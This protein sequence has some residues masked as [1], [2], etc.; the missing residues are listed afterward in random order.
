MDLSFL[1]WLRLVFM[2]C[3]SLV[4][5]VW[6]EPSYALRKTNH[7][8]GLRTY[9]VQSRLIRTDSTS[10]AGTFSLLSNTG[11]R[12]DMIY[13]YNV[14]GSWNTYLEA[15]SIAYG[16]EGPSSRTFTGLDLNTLRYAWTNEIGGR[17]VAVFL[18]L[19]NNP[20]VVLT[21]ESAADFLVDKVDVQQANLGL[22]LTARANGFDLH[23]VGYFGVPITTPLY[24]DSDLTTLEYTLHG[25]FYIKFGNTIRYGINLLYQLDN[26]KIADASYTVNQLGLGLFL[27]AGF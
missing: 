11:I 17:Y 21:E 8:F 1:G 10:S 14:W 18:S 2:V 27:E 13:G 20:L 26:Y 15:G 22:K 7:H 9:A 24:N 5:I 4:A 23:A 16:Y 3:I 12:A 19:E 25:D 6:I